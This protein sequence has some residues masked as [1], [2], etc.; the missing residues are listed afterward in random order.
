MFGSNPP[1]SVSHRQKRKEGESRPSF[2]DTIGITN[3]LLH[4]YRQ[5]PRSQKHRSTSGAPNVAPNGSP[6]P[7]R[8]TGR[9]VSSATTVVRWL[10]LQLPPI[11]HTVPCGNDMF[12]I[13]KT[14]LMEILPFFFGFFEGSGGLYS[15]SSKCPSLSSKRSD[16]RFGTTG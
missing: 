9:L 10:P 14:I 16:T 13:A 12:P 7:P 2:S 8:G 5:F 3:S 15:R 11:L 4:H 6:S 1:T